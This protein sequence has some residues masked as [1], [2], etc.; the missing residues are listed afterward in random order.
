MKNNSRRLRVASAI[1]LGALIIAFAL[2]TLS[3]RISAVSVSP[4]QISELTDGSSD[5]SSKIGEE[6][7]EL[8]GKT[9]N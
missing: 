7:S 4:S 5:F 8:F 2:F 1:I 6:I 3:H 9:L